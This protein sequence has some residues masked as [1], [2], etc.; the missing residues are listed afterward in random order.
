MDV[1][2]GGDCVFASSDFFAAMNDCAPAVIAG[3]CSA[4]DSI[5]IGNAR[6]QGSTDPSCGICMSKAI[7]FDLTRTGPADALAAALAC[8][9]VHTMSVDDCSGE[10]TEVFQGGRPSDTCGMCML[11]SAQGPVA[12]PQDM[13]TVRAD[14][15]LHPPRCAAPDCEPFGDMQPCIAAASSTEEYYDCS[16]EHIGVA[17]ATGSVTESC[18]DSCTMPVAKQHGPGNGNPPSGLAAVEAMY[19]DVMASC[20]PTDASCGRPIPPP[21]PPAPP[22][23]VG[24][25]VVIET[26]SAEEATAAAATLEAAFAPPPAPAPGAPPP[27]PVAVVEITSQV[28]I[29]V[30]IADIAEGSPARADFEAGFKSGMASSIGGGITADK[31]TINGIAAAGRR[32]AVRRALQD[33]YVA[34]DFSVSRDLRCSKPL[35]K[36]LVNIVSVI[37]LRSRRLHRLRLKPRASSPRSTPSRFRRATTCLRSSLL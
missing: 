8:G 28:A 7:E 19:A 36:V 31:I 30:D 15:G 24:V 32:R 29:P 6:Q 25:L 3:S 34:V 2:C 22:P 1:A 10:W 35:C 18:E 4:T 17:G 13:A 27:P 12:S 26:Y 9:P 16:R 5:D 23:P 33:G 14:F 37:A 20:A 21:P 11:I